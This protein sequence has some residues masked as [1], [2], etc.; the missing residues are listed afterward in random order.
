MDLDQFQ[1]VNR[2]SVAILELHRRFSHRF[3][4]PLEFQQLQVKDSRSNQ[5]P[6]LDRDIILVKRGI[7]IRK[8]ILA[9]QLS[10]ASNPSLHIL[11]RLFLP[12]T[13]TSSEIQVLQDSNGQP[14][15]ISRRLE[16][17]RAI[18]LLMDD[19]PQ[20]VL[21]DSILNA[22]LRVERLWNS[23]KRVE[24]LRL[25]RSKLR[26]EVAH[27]KG[28]SQSCLGQDLAERV[29]SLK[30]RGKAM[31]RR[32]KE[33]VEGLALL[34]DVWAVGEQNGDGDGPGE[35]PLGFLQTLMNACLQ[36]PDTSWIRLSSRE[37]SWFKEYLLMIGLVIES[38]SDSQDI[39]L[40][41]GS[42]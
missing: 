5:I 6:P 32:N 16:S 25:E 20:K 41:F 30:M 38:P 33:L 39:R 10:I 15:D 21:V 11:S 18:P 17:P 24:Q 2:D 4:I 36:T 42:A 1:L 8:R 22:K 26:L 29:R 34:S 31:R 40:N 13:K 7:E 19:S 23:G 3:L 28:K 12:E 27:L 9:R 37:M 35:T 14:C